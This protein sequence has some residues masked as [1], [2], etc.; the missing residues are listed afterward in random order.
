MNLSQPISV[1]QLLTIQ[2][3]SDRKLYAYNWLGIAVTTAG[4]ACVGI[5]SVIGNAG[6]AYYISLEQ[7]QIDNNNNN[8]LFVL[9][10]TGKSIKEV[11][12]GDVLIILGQLSNAI[13][14]IIE[15]IFLK[16]RNVCTLFNL[17]YSLAHIHWTV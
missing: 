12:I 7:Q 10:F 3:D 13:Q 15:E 6:G 16:R 17:I 2:H 14:M 5:A 9:L 11:I 1:Y 4:L 8:N